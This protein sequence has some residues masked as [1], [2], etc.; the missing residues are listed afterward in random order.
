MA[1]YQ[2][3][4]TPYDRGRQLL[5]SLGSLWSEIY[6][7]RD[8][9]LSY[10]T[11]KAQ[12][13]TQTMLDTLEMLAAIS[14]YTVPI[15]HKDNW[16]QL[17]LRE[18]EINDA[19]TSL[20]KYD[21]GGTYDAGYRY[22][23]PVQRRDYAF[24]LPA[25]LVKTG[26]VMNR[27]VEPSLVWVEGLDYAVDR[28]NNALVF[29]HNP[30]TDERVPTH[31]IYENGDVIDRGA[32]L[33]IFRGDF[34][35]ETVY[36]QFGYVLGMQ[37]QSSDGYRDLVNALLRSLVR[38]TTRRSVERALSAATGIPL[39]MEGTEQVRVITRDH[40]HRMIITDRH[41][42]KF[43]PDATPVVAV[44]AVVHAGDSLTDALTIH[45]FNR[46]VTP[47]DLDA[48]AM[49]RGFLSHCF[50]ADLVFENREVD[51]V[52][53]EN[54]I[55]GFTY[56]S[57]DLGGFPLDVT[58]F[59]DEMHER[60]IAEAQRAVDACEEPETLTIPGD[61][62]ADPPVDDIVRRRGTLAHL[63]DRRP[64]RVGE[65]TAASLPATINPLQ[66]LVR[67]VLRNNAFLVRV[68]I[69]QLGGGGVGIDTLQ[70]LRKVLPPHTAMLLLLELTANKDSVTLD[71]VNDASLALGIAAEPFSD[72]VTADMVGDSRLALRIVS[73]SCQ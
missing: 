59:F 47:T 37:L 71:M 70:W 3:P 17:V 5:A 7:G 31:Y 2:Y 63:L 14:R 68:K 69:S 53:D 51:L 62:C 72:S 61:P 41:V 29:R 36:R 45:E 25:D 13:E 18:S 50:Y 10:V 52:V 57:F 6:Q 24:P 4:G 21:A 34:D 60:G 48:L 46:G 55:S 1:T 16:F 23:V 28:D 56:V 40:T 66:F 44:D 39:V 64:V 8:Q 32:T 73:G 65:P 12:V 38:G 42:Y 49:G 22:D 35:W 11:A 27:F 15:Y 19:Q 58:K 67:N 9:V 43:H 26:L 33:W 20:L 30:F 54:H